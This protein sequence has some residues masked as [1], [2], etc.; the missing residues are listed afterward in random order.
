MPRPTDPIDEMAV[1]DETIGRLRSRIATGDDSELGPLGTLLLK[2][3]ERRAV[4]VPPGPS[5]DPP[6]SIA[7]VTRKL[8]SV[9]GRPR[10]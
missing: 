7:A 8:R 9:P 4:L 6:G 2:Y 1:L 3:L 5:Q 10:G